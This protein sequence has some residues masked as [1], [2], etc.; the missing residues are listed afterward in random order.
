[1]RDLPAIGY[2]IARGVIGFVRSIGAIR[3]PMG[4]RSVGRIKLLLRHFS[5]RAEFNTLFTTVGI[6]IGLVGQFAVRAE[7]ILTAGGRVVG[8]KVNYL[9]AAVGVDKILA[10]HFAL[11]V[12]IVLTK[13]VILRVAYRDL[14][15]AV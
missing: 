9:P 6:G 1:M 14:L 12:V 15:A 3:N 4:E 11:R 7:E 5:V 10:R 2:L 13:Y 8:I